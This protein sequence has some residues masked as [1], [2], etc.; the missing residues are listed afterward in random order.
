MAA[1]SA[2]SLGLVNS[3]SEYLTIV[4]KVWMQ[5]TAEVGHL[6]EI[7]FRGHGDAKWPLL[8]GSMRNH[9]FTTSEHRY[10]HDFYLRAQPF[11]QEATVPPVDD[12]DWYFLMQHYGVPTRLI[13]WTESALVALFF[14]VQREGPNRPG[15][16]WVLSPRAINRELAKLGNYIPMYS[17]AMVRSYLPPIWDEATVVPAEPI[18]IDPPLNSPRLAAQRGKFTVHGSSDL[19]L[20]TRAELKNALFRIDIPKEAKGRVLRQLVSAGVS[21]SVLFPGLTGLGR[22]LRDAYSSGFDL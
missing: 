19:A 17:Q 20:E 5:W 6:G 18:A 1:Y 16:V 12:W 22:E 21:E 9:Q 2:S 13:D 15:C 4:D 7:W 14:A 3:L 10:R 8:P 11:L